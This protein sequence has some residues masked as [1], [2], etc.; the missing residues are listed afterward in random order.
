MKIDRF[1]SKLSDKGYAKD[2]A[3]QQFRIVKDKQRGN[4]SWRYKV[5]SKAGEVVSEASPSRDLAVVNALSQAV[6]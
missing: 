3:G 5:S 4:R 2:S 1:V 6:L